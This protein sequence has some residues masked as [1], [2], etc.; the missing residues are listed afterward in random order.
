MSKESILMLCNAIKA[1]KKCQNEYDIRNRKCL[2]NQNEVD[3]FIR[4]YEEKKETKQE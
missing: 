4:Q 2:L 3:S 1:F